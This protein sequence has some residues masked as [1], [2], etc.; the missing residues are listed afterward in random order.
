MMQ[1]ED[2]A[3]G[4]QP[5]EVMQFLN[6]LPL[7]DLQQ[8]VVEVGASD[9]I[10]INAN[11]RDIARQVVEWSGS[12]NGCGL[13]KL[14]QQGQ[15]KVRATAVPPVRLWVA[16]FSRNPHFAGRERQ[17]DELASVLKNDNAF[18]IRGLGGIGKTQLAV[19]FAFRC[20]EDRATYPHYP[21]FAFI[22][23]CSADTPERLRTDLDKWAVRLNP[24]LRYRTL[25]AGCPPERPPWTRSGV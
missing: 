12:A 8:L 21:D 4:V 11:R 20:H 19:E 14:Y 3:G 2:D 25:R 7:V 24:Y 17:L 6:R 5:G 18:A 22:L 16:P 1:A 10:T 9:Y 13:A 15:A 23:W